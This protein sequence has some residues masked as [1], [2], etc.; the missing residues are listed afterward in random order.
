MDDTLLDLCLWVDCLDRLRESGQPIYTGDQDIFHPTVFQSVQDGEPEFRAFVLADVHTEHI[1]T[2]SHINPDHNINRTFYN[3]AFVAYMIMDSVHENNRIDLFQR[4]FL[5]FFH[6]RKYLVCNPADGTVRDLDIIEFPHMAFDIICCHSF[7]IHGNDLFFHVLSDRILVFLDDLR[8]KPAFPI[9]W[10]VDLH[11][12]IT[13]MH[14]LLG[15]SVPG[16]IGIFVPVII[17]GISEFFVHLLVESALQDD[18]HHIPHDRIYI[19]SIFDLY[20]VIFQIIAHHFPKG[21]FLWGILFS[22]TI[23]NE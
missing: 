19:G 17:F 15:M 12:T 23:G 13:G 3:P 9:P 16:I 5:P 21:S 1:L 14:G 8:F 10:D 6:D 4:S 20:I 22:T 2:A 7:G 11:I 18:R